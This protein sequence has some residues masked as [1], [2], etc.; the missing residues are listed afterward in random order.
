VADDRYEVGFGKPP[1]H[2]RFQKG[3][4]GN[5]KGPPKGSKNGMLSF[6][7]SWTRR[8]LPKVRKEVAS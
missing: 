5:P 6:G 3:R 4:S 8:S 7:R 2:T 1:K